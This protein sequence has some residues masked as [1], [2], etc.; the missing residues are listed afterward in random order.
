[1]NSFLVVD[2][3][4]D[5]HAERRGSRSIWYEMKQRHDVSTPEAAGIA[6]LY[7]NKLLQ[8]AFTLAEAPE[9]QHVCTAVDTAATGALTEAEYH[10]GE[11]DEAGPEQWRTFCREVSSGLQLPFAMA[12]E[13]SPSAVTPDHVRELSR[14]FGLFEQTIDNAVDDQLPES[15]SPEE[16]LRRNAHR[17]IEAASTLPTDCLLFELFVPWFFYAYFRTHPTGE[18]DPGLLY[19]ASDR[20][21]P[22]APVDG[23]RL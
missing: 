4:L 20:N 7:Q 11:L 6:S 1:M 2:D 22:V 12:A 9:N 21:S 18:V 8:R 16:E 3:L 14:A 23:D 17:T 5:G 13:R 19:R 15:L 10:R